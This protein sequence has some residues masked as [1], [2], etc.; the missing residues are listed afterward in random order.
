MG[1]HLARSPER[2]GAIGTTYLPSDLSDHEP[3]GRWLRGG[4][5]RVAGPDI[6]HVIDTQMWVF[7]QVRGLR[8]NLERARFVECVEIKKLRHSL[9]V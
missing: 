3:M 6:A 8:V 2:E 1:R 5:E 7:E 4:E 9:S